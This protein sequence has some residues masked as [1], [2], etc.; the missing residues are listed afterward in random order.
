MP[1]NIISIVDGGRVIVDYFHQPLS[2]VTEI[3]MLLRV[4]IDVPLELLKLCPIFWPENVK[5]KVEAHFALADL[6]T[7]LQI[8]IRL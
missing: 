3:E 8:F 5:E 6:P 7:L 1:A 4:I 2:V